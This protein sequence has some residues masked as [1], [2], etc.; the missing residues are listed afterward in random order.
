LRVNVG[1]LKQ[2]PTQDDHIF[3]E[4]TT[5]QYY[6]VDVVGEGSGLG[7]CSVIVESDINGEEK[8]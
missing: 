7:V 3:Y 2:I 1:E 6:A 8:Y 4:S 5:T